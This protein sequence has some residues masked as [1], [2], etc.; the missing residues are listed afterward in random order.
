M[1]EYQYQKD[2]KTAAIRRRRALVMRM[3]EIKRNFFPDETDD[4]DSGETEGNGDE[5]E[6]STRKRDKVKELIH[7]SVIKYKDEMET[8]SKFLFRIKARKA[9]RNWDALAQLLLEEY[10]IG[11]EE[12]G[13]L[14][15]YHENEMDEAGTFSEGTF[16]VYARGEDERRKGTGSQS[17]G[18]TNNTSVPSSDKGDVKTGPAPQTGNTTNSPTAQDKSGGDVTGG[19]NDNAEVKTKVWETSTKE[20]RYSE[21]PRSDVKWNTPLTPEQEEKYHWKESLAQVTQANKGWD[22]STL[23]LYT[24]RLIQ[25]GWDVNTDEIP[26]LN[27]IYDREVDAEGRHVIESASYGAAFAYANKKKK[28]GDFTYN[29]FV[30][31]HKVSGKRQISGTSYSSNTAYRNFLANKDKT[32]EV[33]F[34]SIATFTGDDG[35]GFI[36]SIRKIKT[37]ND[38]LLS[39]D[40][41]N[42]VYKAQEK[43]WP[44]SENKSKRTGVWDEETYKKFLSY[45]ADQKQ[46]EEK[47]KQEEQKQKDE[48]AK[49]KVENGWW[50]GTREGRELTVHW[51]TWQDLKNV[52]QNDLDASDEFLE[53]YA[54]PRPQYKEDLAF[55][56]T[57]SERERILA[58][59]AREIDVDESEQK[60]ANM[61]LRNTPPSQYVDMAKTIKWLETQ[62]GMRSWFSHDETISEYSSLRTK[63]MG[64]FDKP[65]ADTEDRKVASDAYESVDVTDNSEDA[66]EDLNKKM[67]SLSPEQIEKFAWYQR[68][69]LLNI[70]LGDDWPTD[71]K[72]WKYFDKLFINIPSYHL[73][74]VKMYLEEN[75]FLALGRM[76]DRL[77]SEGASP[78]QIAAINEALDDW[79]AND[80]TWL[81][82]LKE[83]ADQTENYD[84]GAKEP[85]LYALPN[86]VYSQLTNEERVN[87]YQYV[88]HKGAYSK[89]GRNAHILEKILG[90]VSADL[91]NDKNKEKYNQQ[92]QEFYNKINEHSPYDSMFGASGMSD[93]EKEKI[94]QMVS[95]MDAEGRSQRIEDVKEQSREGYNRMTTISYKDLDAPVTSVADDKIAALSDE[96]MAA[97]YFDDRIAFIQDVVGRDGWDAFFTRV[98]GR[99]EQ[100]LL[101]LI[102][103]TPEE[104]IPWEE[105]ESQNT[106]MKKLMK[107]LAMDSG[108]M[109]KRLQSAID[110]ENFQKLHDNFSKKRYEQVENEPDIKKKLAEKKK[111]DQME[112]QGQQEGAS[113]PWKDYSL[114]GLLFFGEGIEYSADFNEEGKIVVSYTNVSWVD[115]YFSSFTMGLN[116]LG[117]LK[118]AAENVKVYDPWEWVPVYSKEDDEELGLK[119]GEV[120]VMP[121]INLFKY[122]HKQSMG[123]LLELV[124]IVTLIVG[125][126][127]LKAA[128]SLARWLMA[129]ADVFVSAGN[130]IKRTFGDKLPSDLTEGWSELS[131]EIMT[132]QFL[133]MGKQA[134]LGLR[135]LKTKLQTLRTTVR[136]LPA[137]I[138]GAVKTMYN[139]FIDM[140]DEVLEEGERMVS[141]D[142]NYLVRKLDELEANKAEM[143]ESAEG[144]KAYNAIKKYITE[145]ISVMDEEVKFGKLPENVVKESPVSTI[146]QLEKPKPV[147]AGGSKTQWHMRFEGSAEKETVTITMQ[148]GTPY[149]FTR[150]PGEVTWTAKEGDDMANRL[151]SE[152]DAEGTQKM[153]ERIESGDVLAGKK[154][155]RT[156]GEVYENIGQLQEYLKG[157]GVDV[158]IGDEAA[159]MLEKHN[160]NALYVPGAPGKP[161]KMYFR[162]NPT[163]NEVL[164][165]LVHFNQ[166]KQLGFRQLTREELI[167][168]E[169]M[170]QDKMLAWAEKKGWSKE[171]RDRLESARE[172]W[173]EL[174]KKLEANPENAEKIMEEVVF[175]SKRIPGVTEKTIT[176]ALKEIDDLIS[177]LSGKAKIELK[178]TGRYTDVHGHHPLAGSAFEGGSKYIYEEA[179]A[180][181]DK[182][183]E[184]AWKSVNKGVPPNLHNKITGQQRSLYSTFGKTGKQIS[185]SDMVEI[186]IKAM[187]N[188]NIPENIATGWVIKALEDLKAKGVTEITHLPWKIIK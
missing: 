86:S 128:V 125:F 157:K 57:A 146:K 131:E 144:L 145:K 19:E 76:R 187:T 73:G 3:Q 58:A 12:N 88:M 90:T 85:M 89:T 68:R 156:G 98:G 123:H 126:G 154:V 96:D 153:K 121:A 136:N 186:E 87:L 83:V 36:S 103:T 160:A 80:T 141:G 16:A 182:A 104:I 119:K 175:A 116:T 173:D 124:D 71:D 54:A 14:R 50:K 53:D 158:V 166:H 149:T 162:A 11:K 143:I 4:K 148:D 51:Q 142:R 21:E 188:V 75:D 100:T 135:D 91:A 78:G 81:K 84:F 161:G 26:S 39:Q 150:K 95:G 10:K 17:K 152:L 165:E 2:D 7:E 20:Q 15:A 24:R 64:A 171:L 97:L 49:G 183:L 133:Y 45:D 30:W 120:V 170:A 9:R 62:Y 106:D 159:A 38:K 184:D 56:L 163:R 22:K 92:R 60:I 5:K 155:G 107:W 179:F 70:F 66:A 134:V 32:P 181:S 43:I 69:V 48:L 34:E 29:T 115:V 130:M 59:L 137:T 63:I 79:Y 110:G 140:A 55:V 35:A 102:Y 77:K 18:E 178:G 177:K 13:I 46:K 129:A 61:I 138:K 109:Y 112:K 8:N 168:L 37:Y 127:E 44:E 47:K 139:K 105:E 27:N 101:R 31:K 93:E 180:V 151:K 108:T 113:L 6:V 114:L 67:P 65:N 118:E 111:I 1:K 74:L 25:D 164:E 23:I 41:M 147:G 172:E 72:D 42:L 122:T 174:R 185:L 99:D 176:F 40:F 28:E 169:L 167:E 33:D 117:E 52:I 94:T 82:R 132:F